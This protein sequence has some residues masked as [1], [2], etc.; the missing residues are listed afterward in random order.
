MTS[1]LVR[2]QPPEFGRYLWDVSWDLAD[3][4]GNRVMR[5]CNPS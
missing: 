4:L 5:T 2:L 1:V 3:T